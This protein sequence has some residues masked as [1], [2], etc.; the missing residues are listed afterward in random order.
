MDLKTRRGRVLFNDTMHDLKPRAIV[1]DPKKVS[2]FEDIERRSRRPN[3]TMQ[4]LIF[5]SEWS[6]DSGCIKRA[7]MN[8]ENKQVI[9]QGNNVVVWPNGI[10][11]DLQEERLYC[12]DAK[13]SPTFTAI[14]SI[15]KKIKKILTIF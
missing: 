13:V 12:E 7:G 15:K 11:L 5:W 8:G 2:S 1:V 9:L 6:Y 4:G 14:T 3:G 10:A